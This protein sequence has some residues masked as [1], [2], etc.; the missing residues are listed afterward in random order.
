MQE[1]IASSYTYVA[2]GSM[3]NAANEFIPAQGQGNENIEDDI[4]LTLL[5]FQIEWWKF[6]KKTWPLITKWCCYCSA[7]ASDS[8]KCVDFCV[9][10]KTCNACGKTEKNSEPK[11]YE[12]FIETHNCPKN[13]KDSAG[14]MEAAGLVD[15]FM[16]SIKNRKLH[17]IRDGDSKAYNK[18]VKLWKN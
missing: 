7:V 15:C 3:K 5:L 1:K 11:L 18:V 14:S 2:D 4:A 17:Y 13:H 10:T 12:Q 8:G 9:L 6:A 16:N